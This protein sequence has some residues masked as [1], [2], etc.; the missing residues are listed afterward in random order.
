MNVT[1]NGTEPINTSELAKGI[2]LVTFE[3]MNGER[4]VRKMVKK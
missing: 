2:Y 1:L 4:A 3:G